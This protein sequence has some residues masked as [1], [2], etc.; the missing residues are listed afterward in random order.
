M[1]TT[2][3]STIISPQKPTQLVC[4]MSI[5]SITEVLAPGNSTIGHPLTLELISE[6]VAHM[7]TPIAFLSP[8]LTTRQQRI[9][10]SHPFPERL[11]NNEHSQYI[12]PSPYKKK[13]QQTGNEKNK[14]TNQVSKYVPA[15]HHP[16]VP[17][18]GHASSNPFAAAHIF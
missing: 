11:K 15:T 9:P 3:K 6:F 1:N 13:E 18:S 8:K 2:P 5:A 10:F 16:G 17:L 12:P 7:K 14:Q 4:P